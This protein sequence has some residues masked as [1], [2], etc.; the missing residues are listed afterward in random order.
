MSQLALYILHFTVREK[1]IF[2]KENIISK[3]MYFNLLNFKKNKKFYMSSYLF[4]TITYF[5]VF[6]GLNLGR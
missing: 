2:E 6:K 5:H 1:E 4:F 3:E